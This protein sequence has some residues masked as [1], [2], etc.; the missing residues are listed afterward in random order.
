MDIRIQSLRLLFGDLERLRTSKL[1]SEREIVENIEIRSRI[2]IN[3]VIVSL[4]NQKWSED[5]E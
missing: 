1:K 5:R 2:P 3:D 4:C